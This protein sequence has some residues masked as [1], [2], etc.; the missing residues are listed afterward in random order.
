MGAAL[1]VPGVRLQPGSNR[2]VLVVVEVS[3]RRVNFEDLCRLDSELV[4]AALKRRCPV[5]SAKPGEEC[6]AMHGGPLTSICGHYSHLI[7]ADGLPYTKPRKT[8]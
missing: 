7:R 1:G 6:R 3:G 5:C 4:Q 2:A 8:A